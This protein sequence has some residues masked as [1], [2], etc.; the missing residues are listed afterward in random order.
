[1]L[2]ALMGMVLPFSVTSYDS[3]TSWMQALMWSIRASIP[4][5]WVFLLR[6]GKYW[7]R[8]MHLQSSIC[9]SLYAFEEVVVDRIVS[10]SE[11]TVDDAAVDM[12]SKIDT[13]HVIIL[14]NHILMARIW[15]PV[16]G[17]VVQAETCREAHASFQG[18]SGTCSL[19]SDQSTHAVLDLVGELGHGDAW[20]GNPLH[21][22]PNLTMD[23]SGLSIVAQEVLV[24]VADRRQMAKLL[25][26]R[27]LKT[28]ISIEA[29]SL[30]F[31]IWLVLE[32][33]CERHARGTCL[34]SG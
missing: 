24:H 9:C 18:I 23:L 30:T 20:L 19:M 1:L 12:D 13:Q 4:A 14:K 7:T 22:S 31:R 21:V 17:D 34:L 16:G 27:T 5:S 25:F 28:V 29:H 6:N 3:M 10:N 8:G 26:R 11:S 2:I 33:I 15:G 32:D